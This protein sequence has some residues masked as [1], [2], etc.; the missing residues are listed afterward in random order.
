MSG[1]AAVD[2]P[3]AMYLVELALDLASQRLLDDPQALLHLEHMLRRVEAVHFR[4]FDIEKNHVDFFLFQKLNGINGIV[5][6]SHYV[7]IRY[8]FA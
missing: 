3:R 7:K 4:H 5:K 6:F 2:Q 8:S 1:M